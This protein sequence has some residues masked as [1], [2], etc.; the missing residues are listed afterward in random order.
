MTL[1]RTTSF[2]M[3][4]ATLSLLLFASSAPSPLYVVYQGQWDFSALTLTAVFAVYAFALLGALLVSGSVSDHAGRRPTLIVGLLVEIVAMLAFAEATGVGWLL[5]ARAL[6]G[7]ATGVA[8]GSISAALLDLQPRSRPWLGGLV[9]A[10]A[11]MSGLAVGAL[12]TGLLVDHAPYPTRLVFWLLLGAFAAA[13]ALAAAV[14][15]TVESNGRWKTTLRPRAGVPVHLRPMFAAALPS[16]AATWALGGLVLSLGPSITSEI[17]GAG[18]H[19]VGALPIFVMAGVSAVM[20]VVIRDLDPRAAT[21]GGLVALIAGVS[22]ALTAIVAESS[23]LFLA[24]ATICGL[25]FGPAFA[26]VFRVLTQLAPADR[27]GEMVSSVLVVAYLA[28]SGPA[29]VAGIAVTQVGL[30]ETALVYGGVLIAMAALALA[31]SHR[32]GVVAPEHAEAVARV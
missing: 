28:F 13:L 4:A 25:G 22:V 30:R 31:L 6:Q 1:S 27:R 20:S 17:L 29:L 7:V 14:P 11:P 26:G 2:W 19:L 15:E 5:A 9:G 21:R 8:M 32:L 16:L 18:S 3:L 10:V 23:L 12:M 24:G